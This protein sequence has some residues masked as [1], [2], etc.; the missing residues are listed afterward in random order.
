MLLPKTEQP[1]DEDDREND[2]R[3]GHVPEEN[4]E[5]GG[6][7]EDENDRARELPQEQDE[8]GRVLFRAQLIRAKLGETLARLIAR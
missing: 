8:P 1:A 2:R 4:R 7:D 3:V 5:H 6:A